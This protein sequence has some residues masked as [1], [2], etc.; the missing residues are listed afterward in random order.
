MHSDQVCDRT[1]GFVVEFQAAQ[2]FICQDCPVIIMPNKMCYTVGID[3]FVHGFGTVVQKER[4]AEDGIFLLGE[5]RK[6][7]VIRILCLCYIARCFVPGK[8]GERLYCMHSHVVDMV[9]VFLRGRKHLVKFRQ[10][11]GGQPSFAC[12]KQ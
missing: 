6:P 12:G 2:N 8:V 11:Y 10:E 1:D 9:R 3:I 4:K 5:Q 7:G